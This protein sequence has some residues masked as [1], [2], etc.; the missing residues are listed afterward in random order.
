MTPFTIDKY[1]GVTLSKQMKDLY[2]K[3]FKILKEELTKLS[4]DGKLS[5]AHGLVGLI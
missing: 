3:I 1:L 2:D 4:E 5:Y